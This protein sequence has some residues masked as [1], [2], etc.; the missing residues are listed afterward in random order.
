MFGR[1]KMYKKGLED[2]MRA[3]EDFGK[4]QEEAIK[5]LRE[6]VK[7]GNK[8]L[9]DM[10]NEIGENINGVYDYLTDREKAALY[11]LCTPK[12]IKELD[13]SERRLLVA[14]LYQLANDEGGWDLTD[15]QK[16]Y[17]RS[18]QKYLEITNPQTEIDLSA[19]E[20][21]DSI[22]SQKVIL[23]VVLE[24]MYLQDSDEISDQQED[25]LGY[26]SLNKKQ[27]EQIEQYVAKLYNTVGAEGICEKY[28]F[29][30][31][32]GELLYASENS[33]VNANVDFYYD[34]R[35]GAARMWSD[36]R[37]IFE[38]REQCSLHNMRWTDHLL[39][40]SGKGTGEWIC[41][42]TDLR[43]LQDIATFKEDEVK[44]PISLSPRY[45]TVSSKYFCTCS[46]MD[47]HCYIVKDYTN[48][49][50]KEFQYNKYDYLSIKAIIKSFLI[51]DCSNE[52]TG[53]PPHDVVIYNFIDD[54]SEIIDSFHGNYR[55]SNVY[56]IDE[57]LY[58]VICIDKGY[59]EKN[60]Y[61]IWC[62]DLKLRKYSWKQYCVFDDLD[63][64]SNL[65]FWDQIL[66]YDGKAEIVGNDIEQF[67]RIVFDLKDGTL[68]SNQKVNFYE[69]GPYQYIQK[70]DHTIICMT[71][72]YGC[73][74]DS[75]R[76][77]LTFDSLDDKLN[78]ERDIARENTEQG[79]EIIEKLYY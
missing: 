41:H 68:L 77:L 7:S 22:E 40:W 62:Y 20:N 34:F 55:L 61:D 1:K 15:Y 75:C 33:G 65:H 71:F 6:E 56:A 51:L 31:D 54:T 13:E 42:V 47:K 38:P 32:E 73:D 60:G 72:G 25:F 26:F 48:S 53:V 78:T 45:G 11:H 14:V 39:I 5:K 35:I 2:A 12:D 18:V 10:L 63:R 52:M 30:D 29:V 23:Q 57:K 9:E 46:D 59:G 69:G 74:R 27:A 79:N 64:S 70:I 76:S 50:Y 19:I 8:K 17:V 58:F 37:V 28:G 21:I 66:S 4:K 43:T 36:N 16:K 3:Y 24:F 49:F 67:R 44:P